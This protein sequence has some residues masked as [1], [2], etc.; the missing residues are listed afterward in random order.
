MANPPYI[1]QTEDNV[2]ADKMNRIEQTLVRFEEA[3]ARLE[4]GGGY[5][6]VFGLDADD[7][8]VVLSGDVA[9]AF[10]KAAAG[11]ALSCAVLYGDAEEASVYPAKRVQY[12]SEFG[13]LGPV[14]T[15]YVTCDSWDENNLIM[16]YN[17][18]G[19]FYLRPDK[20]AVVWD[21]WNS[22]PDSEDWLPLNS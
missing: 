14:I 12:A 6:I 11:G 3:L 16:V 20:I 4:D 9:A 22:E 13:D 5:D 2:P 21:S 18:V 7:N 10:A 1:W 8:P 19:A 15:A 17:D